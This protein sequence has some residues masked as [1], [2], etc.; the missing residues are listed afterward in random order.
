MIKQYAIVY[1]L[2]KLY[3]NIVVKILLWELWYIGKHVGYSF[4]SGI[5]LSVVNMIV[6]CSLF[7]LEKNKYDKASIDCFTSFWL[8]NQTIN[9]VHFD[10]LF[11]LKFPP[12]FGSGLPRKPFLFDN[13][14]YSFNHVHNLNKLDGPF[15]KKYSKLLQCIMVGFWNF[16]TLNFLAP[17]H[18]VLNISQLL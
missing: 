7:Y 3:R 5:N 10:I 6:G 12:F 9:M 18:L 2:T 17:L 11:S 16:D 13:L 15:P 1:M 8:R 4:S 14:L